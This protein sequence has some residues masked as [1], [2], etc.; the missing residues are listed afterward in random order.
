MNSFATLCE[1][2]LDVHQL[3]DDVETSNGISE[4]QLQ[5]AEDAAEEAAN[6]PGTLIF[7]GAFFI[8]YEVT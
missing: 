7:T 5:A 6:D 2:D 8:I 1:G 3:I 4:E